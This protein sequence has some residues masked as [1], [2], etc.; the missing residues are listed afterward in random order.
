MGSLSRALRRGRGEPVSDLSPQTC[1]EVAWW[2][3]HAYPEDLFRTEQGRS[4]ARPTGA[5]IEGGQLLTP[6]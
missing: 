1:P 4:L 2:F 5:F 6:T 3:F